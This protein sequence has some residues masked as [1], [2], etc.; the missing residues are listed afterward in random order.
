MEYSKG[1]S[2]LGIDVDSLDPEMVEILGVL[3][4]DLGIKTKHSCIGHSDSEGT[5]IMFDE[6]VD[7]RDMLMLVEITDENVGISGAVAC[8]VYSWL[9]MMYRPYYQEP[10]YPVNSWILEIPKDYDRDFRETQLERVATSLKRVASSNR[11]SDK[12]DEV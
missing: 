3:N 2:D 4:V 5:Y 10:H 7:Y 6:S 8:R 9:R 12:Y 11:R 1:L